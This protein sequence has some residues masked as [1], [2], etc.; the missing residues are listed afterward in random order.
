MLPFGLVPQ[1]LHALHGEGRIAWQQAVYAW[2]RC[3]GKP[4][5]SSFSSSFS[6]SNDGVDGT[7]PSQ[8]Q[9]EAKCGFVLFFFFKNFASAP[10]CADSFYVLQFGYSP[11]VHG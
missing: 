10:M 7:L 11:D 5:F 9:N 2:N 3:D 6:Q 8:D 4:F 1:R